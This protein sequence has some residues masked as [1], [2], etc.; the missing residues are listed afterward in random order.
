MQFNRIHKKH[1]LNMQSFDVLQ[2]ETNN[3]IKSAPLDKATLST[4]DMFSF[5]FAMKSIEQY[6]CDKE[7]RL[8]S[9]GIA[10][11]GEMMACLVDMSKCG[12]SRMNSIAE[13]IQDKL[14]YEGEF[15]DRLP[16]LFRVWREQKETLE[17]VSRLIHLTHV[18]LFFTSKNG[19]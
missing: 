9:I 5:N 8:L 2:T 4:M 17:Y 11:L 12:D 3:G 19:N 10:L 1:E 16:A 7:Y 13:S 18:R 15:L 14:F 6:I